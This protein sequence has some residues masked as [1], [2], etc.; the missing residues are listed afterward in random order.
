MPTKFPKCSGKPAFAAKECFEPPRWFIELLEHDLGV[1]KARMMD[2]IEWWRHASLLQPLD[3]STSNSSD[4]NARSMGES[5]T[6][7]LE[8]DDHSYATIWAG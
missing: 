3:Q 5:P 4:E 8:H 1:P 7:G 2:S 6:V